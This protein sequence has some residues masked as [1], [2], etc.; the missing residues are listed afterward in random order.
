VDNLVLVGFSCS[1]KTTIGR[2]LARRLHLRFVDTD[3]G[4][5]EQEAVTI[6]EIFAERGE[7]AF[8]ALEREMV[9]RVCRERFQVIST[10]G[11]TFVDPEN[12]RLL[13]H[14]NLVAMLRVRPETVVKRLSN[15]RRGRPRPLLQAEDPLARVRELMEARREAYACAHFAVDVDDRSTHALVEDVAR[16]W[17]AWRR[18]VRNQAAAAGRARAIESTRA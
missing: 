3:R 16:R 8:R 15:S 11:G 10:G 9:A 17:F 7:A 4:I 1:G 13:R 2:M 6:P 5:E 14:A 12:Q 18:S